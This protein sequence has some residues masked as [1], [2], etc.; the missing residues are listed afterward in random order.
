[1]SL[2]LQYIVTPLFGALIG[3]ITNDVA[4][5]MLFHP[6]KPKY[7]FGKKLPFTPGLIPKERYRI[8]ASIGEAVSENL[9]NEAV[10]QQTLLSDEMKDKVLNAVSQYVD[11]F[12]TSSDTL[13][14]ALAKLLS[15]EQM[16]QLES[17]TAQRL[18]ATVSHKLSH[19]GLG[20]KI[21]GMAVEHVINKGGL[22]AIGLSI[23]RGKVEELLQTN[24]DELLANHSEAMVGDM[25]Q[26][27]LSNILSTPVAKLLEGKQAMLQSLKQSVLNVYCTTVE[28]QMPRILA[29]LDIRRIVESRI[30]EMDIEEVEDII[31]KIAKKELNAIVWFGAVLGF[32]VGIFN[33]LMLKF[34]F[35]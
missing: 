32:I 11:R 1:M 17:T 22:P 8:S 18:T 27:G 4:I 15:S 29:A 20:T 21:A 6:V 34:P 5:R 10:M 23:F 7:L 24:I 33:A 9:M 25:V 35:M 2:M 12:A 3:Y 19:S 13:R 30:N 28:Q 31:L 16:R 14:E 26:G